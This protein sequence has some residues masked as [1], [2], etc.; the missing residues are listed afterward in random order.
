M[1]FICIF[2]GFTNSLAIT[3]YLAVP[4]VCLFRYLLTTAKQFPEFGRDPRTVV[5]L[6]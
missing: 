3:K 2:P 1:S 4:A 6:L 5:R